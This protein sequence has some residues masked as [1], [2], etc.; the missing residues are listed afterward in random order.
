MSGASV[1]VQWLPLEIGV[2]AG[3]LS[4]IV[5]LRS[6]SSGYPGYP[7][8][9]LSQLAIGVIAALIGGSVVTSL[10]AKQFT[11]ATFLT[12]AA[13]Q[14]FDLRQ[15]ER[16]TL[17]KED[18]LILVARGA[19]YIEGI[20]R[21]FEARN[22]LS[23]LVALAASGG[24]ALWGPWVGGAVGAV[25]IVVSLYLMQ[26]PV[27]G[28][29]IDVKPSPIHFEKDSL[30]YVGDVM[31]MEVGLKHTREQWL[32]EGLGVVLMPKSGR[33]EAALWDVSQRQALT[34][35]AAR[36]VGAKKDVGYP[37]YSPLTRMQMPDANGRGAL[38]IIPVEADVDRLI[39]AVRRTPVLESTKWQRVHYTQRDTHSSSQ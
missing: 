1:P 39:D 23:M 16:T 7:S 9:Y 6:G 27:M 28:D 32:K 2:A 14:F 37:D 11:A 18:R 12:L 30:L 13:T 29:L 33:G 17:E 5:S 31:L 3:L 36:A 35:E 8:G 20:A 10:L 4:R 19:G 22:Y 21:T 26:G 38:G 15:T 25:L 24:T 34:H